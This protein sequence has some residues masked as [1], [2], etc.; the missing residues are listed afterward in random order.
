V[1]I[2]SGYE[3]GYDTGRTA[4]SLAPDV[5]GTW[6]YARAITR[7]GDVARQR[8]LLAAVRTARRHRP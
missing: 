4:I 6:L 3:Y 5:D 7:S 1:W 2:A 8:E